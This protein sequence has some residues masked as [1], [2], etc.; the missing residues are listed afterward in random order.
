MRDSKPISSA[1]RVS[2]AWRI[3]SQSDWLPMM[4]ATGFAGSPT[5]ASSCKGKARGRTALAAPSSDNVGRQLIF[6]IGQAVAQDQL[7]FLQ[8]LDLQLIVLADQLQRLDGGVEIAMFLPHALE[9]RLERR[10][11]I[12]AEPVP[13]E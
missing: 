9:F 7:A 10:A 8:P 3:V 11:L 6:E 5:R 4:M 13:H 12:I 2:A 1:A